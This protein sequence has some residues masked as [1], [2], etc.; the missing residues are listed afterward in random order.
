MDSDRRYNILRSLT[1]KRVIQNT[2]PQSRKRLIIND[3]C[4]KLIILTAFLSGVLLSIPTSAS[5]FGVKTNVLYDATAT[6]NLGAELRVA[7]KWSIDVSGNLNA[8]SFNGGRRWKH[9]MA[10]PEVRYWLCDAMAGHF[11]ALHAIGGQFNFGHLPFA[12]DIVYDFSRL[13]DKRYQGW[14]VGAGLGYGY[15]WMLGRHWNF[16]AELGIGWIRADY[17]EFECEGC[18]KKVGEGVKNMILPT[19]AAI[20]IVYIF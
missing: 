17:D 16:E 5:G 7:P 10:Q 12:T 19:K 14:A 13:R 6:I 18:G 8:W 11:F 15:S 4:K 20:N 9:W 1:G 2:P 3:L